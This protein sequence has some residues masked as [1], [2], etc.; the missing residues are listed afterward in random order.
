MG[1]HFKGFDDVVTKGLRV[2]SV[3]RH[4]FARTGLGC[5]LGQFMV[6]VAVASAMPTRLLSGSVDPGRSHF[7]HDVLARAANHRIRHKNSEANLPMSRRHR[8]VRPSFLQCDGSEAFAVALAS[9]RS[10]LHRIKRRRAAGQALLEWAIMMV[11]LLWVCVGGVD[12][13]RAYSTYI[14]LTNAARVG[15]R[16]ATLPPD[17]VVILPPGASDAQVMAQ[18][19][20]EQSS[21]GIT[22]SMIVVDRSQPDRRTVTITYPFTPIT[23]L[24]ARLGDGTTLPL[25]TWATMP[26]MGS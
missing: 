22:D 2:M 7:A 11:V 10:H 4:L 13:G 16:Y 19:R 5:R 9:R 15:A 6:E 20:A 25:R 26:R 12:F 24:V 14:G 23:P 1:E 18:V 8:D 3:R 21:L 17:G